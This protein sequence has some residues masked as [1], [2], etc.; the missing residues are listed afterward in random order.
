MLDLARPGDRLLEERPADAAPAMRRGDHQAEVGDVP[1]RRV[2]GRGRARGG[3][4]AAV[5]RRPRRRRPRRR[6]ASARGG[7]AA[8]R[9]RCASRPSSSSQPPSSRPTAVPSS[10]SAAASS[11]RAGRIAI[12]H[13]TIPWPP[14]RG[15]AGR[16][17]RPVRTQLDRGDAAEVEVEALPRDHLPRA[18]GQLRGRARRPAALE[19]QLALADD[20]ETRPR[21]R[22][23][24][25]L[26]PP[27]TASATCAIAPASRTEPALPSISRGRPS[28]STSVG[29]IMLA[30][31]SPGIFSS[32]PITSNSPSMLFSCVPRAVDA[33]ARA[34]RRGERGGVPVGVDDGDVRRA[35]D[36]AERV[37]RRRRRAAR[38][39]ARQRGRSPGEARRAPTATI[40]P[41]REGGGV[42]TTS[43]P[44]IVGAQRLALDR[45]GTRR[46]RRRARAPARATAASGS[47]RMRS[48][49]G[50]EV[51][52]VEVLAVPVDAPAA[53]VALQ[54][55]GRG[56]RAGTPV[57]GSRR[58]PHGRARSQA[59]R[60]RAQGSLPKRA[61]GLDE[62]GEQPRNGDRALADVVA[63]RGASRSRPSAPRSPRAARV[64][65][66]KK[67]S[68]SVGSPSTCA[69]KK[70]PPAGPGQRALGDERGERGRKAGVDRIAA[71][72]E[73]AGSCFGSERMARCDR[74]LSSPKRKPWWF[75]PTMG[76]RAASTRPDVQCTSP[77]T[78][79]TTLSLSALCVTRRGRRRRDDRRSCS[80]TRCETASRACGEA[81]RAWLWIAALGFVGSLVASGVRL[82]LGARPLRRRDL[83]RSTRPRATAS[84]RSSTRSRPRSSAPPCASRLFSRV[85]HSE[86][87]IWTAGGI[88]TSDRRRALGL[89]R[90][91]A[92][93]RRRDAARCPPT[94]SAS[95]R[96]SRPLRSRP[97]TS[98]ATRGPD[99]RIAHSSTRSASSAAAHAPPAQMLGWIGARDDQPHRRRDRDRR[100]P[101]A[102]RT[103]C[104]RQCWSFPRS[105]SPARCR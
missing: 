66:A 90:G 92:H 102:S 21:D 16:V 100:P 38:A 87:R 72:C 80:A 69:R 63:L 78:S 5:V 96:S 67:Q 61:V 49:V 68:I 95:S 12:A 85:L 43:R 104:S 32:W 103:R 14:R 94:R 46:G 1:A 41:P 15:I 36:A 2:A 27:T 39:R 52:R 20:V 89:A 26:A 44:S 6:S 8:R 105:S 75:L 73:Y 47:S 65:T 76:E 33:R 3:R 17:E 51:A 79:K 42:V 19:V 4:R 84:D 40:A 83:A 45:R 7:S 9:R 60:G 93:L 54:D 91:D 71:V 50:D 48:S 74:C 53:L 24:R 64:G 58:R 88:G 35:G 23:G 25:R 29:V 101:S 37:R 57:R 62:A 55:C 22:L 97:P 28:S 13:T 98:H 86:R 11:G 30:R 77:S 70:P 82:A 31:R 99:G 56:S 10:T 18:F 59:R 81:N 34:E